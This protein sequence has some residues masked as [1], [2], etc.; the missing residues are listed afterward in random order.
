MIRPLH[1]QSRKRLIVVYCAESSQAAS[2][3]LGAFSPFCSI[4]SPGALKRT[5][6]P[7]QWEDPVYTQA[8]SFTVVTGWSLGGLWVS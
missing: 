6:Y 2:R 8:A 3:S 7:Y 1:S 5:R 4:Q